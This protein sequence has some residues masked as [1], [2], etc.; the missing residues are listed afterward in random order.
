MQTTIGMKGA[1]VQPVRSHSTP[2]MIGT[3][4]AQE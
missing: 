2:L 4:T 3:I 1:S